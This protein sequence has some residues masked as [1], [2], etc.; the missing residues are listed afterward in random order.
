L[1]CSCSFALTKLLFSATEEEAAEAYDI[2]ALKFRGD[3]A[4]TNFEP[5]RYNLEAIARSDLP[6]NG[7][8]RRLNSYNYKP[9]AAPEAQQVQQITFATSAP[10][11]PQ[12]LSNGVSPCLLHTLLQ[13]PPSAA[14]MHALPLSSYGGVGVPAF[15]WPFGEVE[16]KVQLDG[17]M[18]VVDGILQLANP[19]V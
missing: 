8:G 17:K 13:L 16:Q 7:P 6:I 14:P 3:N 11:F 1:A 2:A 12:Q 9:P 5:S 15:Y 18:E 19:A 4:V 10:P